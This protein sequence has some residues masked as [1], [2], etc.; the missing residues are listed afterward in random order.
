MTSADWTAFSIQN[1]RAQVAR[2]TLCNL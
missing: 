2:W 1:T